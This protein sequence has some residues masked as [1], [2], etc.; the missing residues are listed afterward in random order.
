[1]AVKCFAN[2]KGD[3]NDGL[4]LGLEG[5]EGSGEDQG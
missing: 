5:L 1:M 2:T 4:L 3:N